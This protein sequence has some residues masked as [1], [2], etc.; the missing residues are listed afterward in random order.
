MLKRAFHAKLDVIPNIKITDHSKDPVQAALLHHERTLE[1]L[2]V[3]SPPFTDEELE[4]FVAA[5][6]FAR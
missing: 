4:E 1:L 6:K 2:N 3:P 5:A